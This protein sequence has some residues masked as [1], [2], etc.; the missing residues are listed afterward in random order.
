MQM[1][2]TLLRTTY[3]INQPRI[4]LLP[5]SGV[6]MPD[7]VPRLSLLRKFLAGLGRILK[8]LES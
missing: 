4:S 1:H 3:L 5:L 7:L 6:H 2:T 8:S